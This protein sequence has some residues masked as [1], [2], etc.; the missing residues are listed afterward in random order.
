MIL[1]PSQIKS[2]NRD[3]LSL[4]QIMARLKVPKWETDTETGSF[5][6]NFIPDTE[7]IK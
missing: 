4:G 5:L 3:G 6:S 2:L 1:E 7:L